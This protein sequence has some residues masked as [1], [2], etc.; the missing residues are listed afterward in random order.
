MTEGTPALPYAS[1]LI[2]ETKKAEYVGA[3][4]AKSIKKQKVITDPRASE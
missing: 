3:Y 2:T 1:T 4:S